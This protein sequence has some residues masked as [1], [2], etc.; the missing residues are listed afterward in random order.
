MTGTDVAAPTD[1]ELIDFVIREDE[2]AKLG[3]KLQREAGRVVLAH[4][5]ATG[6][7]HA[8]DDEHVTLYADPT[9]TK[10]ERHLR[11]VKTSAWLKHEE[12][13]PIEL[14]AGLHKVRRQK[15]YDPRDNR[16]VAD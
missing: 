8:L 6:H 13:A 9:P 5:E 15:E 12:H 4:G 10:S 16:M 7:A 2:A 3:D 1:Q 14:P 11:I